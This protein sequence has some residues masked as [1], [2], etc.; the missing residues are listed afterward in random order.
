[1]IYMATEEKYVTEN[2]KILE[3]KYGGKYIA[4]HREKVIATGRTIPE[5][6][7][8]LEDLNIDNPLITYIPKDKKALT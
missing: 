7:D 6:Q 3:K 2:R 8:I 5:I 4:V 1:M